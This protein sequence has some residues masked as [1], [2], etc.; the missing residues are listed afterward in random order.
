MS[1]RIFLR[2]VQVHGRHGVFE[3]ER[4]LGQRFIFDVDY[5][6]DA[7]VPARTDDVASSVS[8]ADIHAAIVEIGAGEPVALLETLAE[9]L[10]QTI[11]GRFPA[12][13]QVRIEV[14]KPSA[15]IVGIF[16]DVGVEIIRRRP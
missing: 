10:A 15:P 3:E 13:E 7:S 1:D 2:G 6:L 4:R 16:S 11:L 5:W 9:N 8:Y 12:I 14:H